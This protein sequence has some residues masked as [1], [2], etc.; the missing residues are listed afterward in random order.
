MHFLIFDETTGTVIIPDEKTV[1]ITSSRPFAPDV[2]EQL[3]NG[4][5]PRT[6]GK[7]QRPFVNQASSQTTILDDAGYNEAR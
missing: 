6:L 3:E 2:T 7:T 5:D 4:T 1:I